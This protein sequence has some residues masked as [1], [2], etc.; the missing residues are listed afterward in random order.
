MTRRPTQNKVLDTARVRQLALHYAARY[1]TSRARL[2]RYLERKVREAEWGEAEA[3]DI[4]AIVDQLAE[5][6]YIDDDAFVRAKASAL[7]RKGWSQSKIR[8]TLLSDGIGRELIDDQNILEEAD[9]FATA[10][11]FAQRKRLG[12]FFK[13]ELRPNYSSRWLGALLRAGHSASVARR[14]LAMS[15]QDMA[16]WLSETD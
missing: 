12:P 11:R 6:R 1:L 13:G 14:V 4:I 2:T 16:E 3:P 5:M 8:W 15:A 9:E 7:R 10:I